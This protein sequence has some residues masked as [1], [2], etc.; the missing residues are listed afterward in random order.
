MVKYKNSGKLLTKRL[1]YF[2]TAYHEV[3]ETML[4]TTVDDNK[5]KFSAHDFSRAKI[6]RVL[7]RII[8]RPMIND[9]IHYVTANIIPN[10]PITVQDIQ[11]ANFVVHKVRPQDSHH[12]GFAWKITPYLC[13]SC[14]NTK[15]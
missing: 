3:E 6:A 15:T 14:N 9:F 4:I 8:G 5:S 13:K 1:Y 12:L 10:C 7:Q 11:N 2:D